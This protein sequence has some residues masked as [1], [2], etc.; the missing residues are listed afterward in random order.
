MVN[1]DNLVK[2]L[3]FI[4][5]KRKIPSLFIS[6]ITIIYLLCVKWKYST[7]LMGHMEYYNKQLM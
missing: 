5:T 6:F 7:I 1:K 4:L 3:V 2:I